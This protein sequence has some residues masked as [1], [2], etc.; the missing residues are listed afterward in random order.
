MKNRYSKNSLSQNSKKKFVTDWQ[1]KE[2]I[3]QIAED[4]WICR[5]KIQ[6]ANVNFPRWSTISQHK[7]ESE[8]Q[9]AY[10]NYNKK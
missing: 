8:A 9:E 1:F 10:D 2:G 4:K 5:V 3:F 7:T 6:E